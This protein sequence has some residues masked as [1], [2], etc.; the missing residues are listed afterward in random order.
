MIELN[1]KE[2]CLGCTACEQICPKK[3]I[4]MK[5]DKEGFYYPEIKKD[6]CINCNLCN[7]TCP[8]INNPLKQCSQKIY[9]VQSKDLNNR[10]TSSSGGVFPLLANFIIE[11]NGVVYGCTNKID[12]VHP[13]HIRLTDAKDL[14]LLKGS[15][16]VQ[17]DLKNTFSLVKKDLSDGRKVLFSGTPCQCSGLRNFLRKEYDNLYVVDLLCHGV[18]SPKLY[19]EN[20]EILEH[21]FQSKAKSLNLRSKEKSWKRLF[22]KVE[23]ENGK[24]YFKFSGYDPYMSLFLNNKSQRPS[25]F[26]CPF[27]K[28]DRI[29]DITLGD[30][31]GI[32]NH[33]R[34]MDD[35]KGTSMVITNSLK[36]RKLFSMIE[37]NLKYVE[38]T[39]EV[40]ESGNKVLCEPARKNKDRDSFYKEYEIN[41]LP[42]A[43]EKYANVP[44]RLGQMKGNFLKFGI[45]IYRKIF[46]K[47]Y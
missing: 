10:K 26:E 1:R 11:Q 28:H 9:A 4:T 30:F 25:C 23:F 41:G 40:A 37:D 15:V 38:T 42:S 3:C 47:T 18:P 5:Q 19:K 46:R 44:G 22:A 21:E 24:K 33:I 17:S 12:V 7:K 31:W 36:G 20:L 27:T 34:E 13:Q 6:E 39:I 45:D 29:G 16:Y 43:Y 14:F 2:D 32:A 8:K 35:D